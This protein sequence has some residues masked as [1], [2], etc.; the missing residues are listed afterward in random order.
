MDDEP[1]EEG[2]FI[3]ILDQQ[4]ANMKISMSENISE[5]VIVQIRYKRS[6]MLVCNLAEPTEQDDIKTLPPESKSSPTKPSSQEQSQ[7]NPK[8]KISDEGEQEVFSDISDFVHDDHDSKSDSL[9]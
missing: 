2:D 1:Y 8:K 9:K 5:G 4:K 6:G 7:S 3:E